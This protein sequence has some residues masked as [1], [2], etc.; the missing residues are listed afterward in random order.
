MFKLD[1]TVIPYNWTILKGII[2]RQARISDAINKPSIW[3]SVYTLKF[4]IDEGLI[5]TETNKSADIQHVPDEMNGNLQPVLNILRLLYSIVEEQS[6][7]DFFAGYLR[8]LSAEFVN[9]KLTAKLNRQL[10]ESLVIASDCLPDWATSLTRSHGFLFPF[11]SRFNFLQSTSFGYSRSMHRWLTQDNMNN[12]QRR[13]DNR[14][15]TSVGTLSRQK[16][17]VSRKRILESAMKVMDMYGSSPAI[18]EIEYYDEVGTGLGPTLEFY[19]SVSLEV[20]LSNLHMWRGPS[21]TEDYVSTKSGLFPR[22]LLASP[23]NDNTRKI[24][25]LF[26]FLG[27]FVARSML[28]SRIIDL[29]FNPTFF[30]LLQQESGLFQPSGLLHFVD[31]ELAKSIDHLES[32]ISSGDEDAVANLALDFT[33]PGYPEIELVPAAKIFLSH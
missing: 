12:S 23:Q 31:K 7:A 21:T 27:Q 6:L 17:R 29:D 26:R 3:N 22:P 2:D 20:T 18:I 11:E 19:S 8:P 33:L 5:P 16:V 30:Y 1:D 9:A 13:N 10:E 24:F 14:R 28:D 25:A 4:S 32:Y 15:P